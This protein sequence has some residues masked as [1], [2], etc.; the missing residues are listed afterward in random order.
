MEISQRIVFS[1]QLVGAAPSCAVLWRRVVSEEPN[2]EAED[3]DSIHRDNIVLSSVPSNTKPKCL[4]TKF[5]FYGETA[6]GRQLKM[7]FMGLLNWKE[8]KSF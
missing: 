1:L 7:R 8:N 6:E 2:R 5:A 3:Q 4:L